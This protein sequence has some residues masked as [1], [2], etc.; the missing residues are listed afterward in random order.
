MVKPFCQASKHLTYV[1]GF[2]QLWI[3]LLSLGL[4]CYKTFRWPCTRFY[5][6]PCFSFAEEEEESVDSLTAEIT[7]VGL[8]PNGVVVSETS[9]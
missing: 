5:A 7:P 3:K 8:V 2:C 4:I 1:L 9:C 6:D